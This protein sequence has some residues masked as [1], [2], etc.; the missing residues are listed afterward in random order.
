MINWFI[1]IFGIML[2]FF[3][4]KGILAQ[5]AQVPYHIQAALFGKIFK[6]IPQF[7]D[8]T[9]KILIVYNTQSESEKS[10]LMENIKSI[11]F[12]ANAIEPDKL[13]R[14]ISGHDVVYFMSGLQN[15][16]SLCKENL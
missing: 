7:D 15:Y 10:I 11:G 6:H 12:V 14:E 13:V 9:L 2:S 1:L 5:S 3:N 4:T 16:A 8:K